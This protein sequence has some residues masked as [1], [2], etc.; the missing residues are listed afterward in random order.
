MAK[1][2][3]FGIARNSQPSPLA[4]IAPKGATW[5]RSVGRV[6]VT[7]RDAGADDGVK[8][9]RLK[10]GQS[11]AMAGSS[12]QRRTICSQSTFESHST[13][14][15]DWCLLINRT[16]GSTLFVYRMAVTTKTLIVGARATALP[17]EEVT[18]DCR[19]IRCEWPTIKERYKPPAPANLG[20]P[21]LS[22]ATL[23]PA[24]Q[25]VFLPSQSSVWLFPN[26]ARSS[27]RS[28]VR[29]Y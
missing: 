10:I 13:S 25:Q 26:V 28:L 24:W 9:L 27:E 18:N 23:V 4:L 15:S 14:S 6:Q 16:Q 3:T 1:W 11:R 19:A 2:V 7:W 29:S 5:F 22:R 8:T 17:S 21:V 20:R 12:G